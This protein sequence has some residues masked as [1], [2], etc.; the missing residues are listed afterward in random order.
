MESTPLNNPKNKHGKAEDIRSGLCGICPAGCWVK[1]V[2]KDD[3]MVSV[4]PNSE[5]PM[6]AICKIGRYSP[7]IVHD[8]QRLLYPLK[9]TGPKGTHEFTRISWDEAFTAIVNQLQTTKAKYGPEATAIYTGRGSFDMALCDH[10]QPEGVAVSSASSLLFPFG[11]PNTLGVGALCYVSFAM[12]APH[13]TMGE[14]YITMDGD[15]EQA[16]LIVIWGAN[17]ATD[18]PPWTHEQILKAKKRGAEVIAIDP[19]RN[20]TA[21]EADAQWIPIRPGT[22]GALALGLINILISEESYDEDFAENW[23]VGFDELKQLT[24]HYRAEVVEEITGVPSATIYSLARKIVSARGAVPVMYTGLEYSDSGVQAIRGVFTLWA[25]AGQLDTPGGLL[26]RMKE[27]QF[28]QNRTALQKNPDVKKALGRDRF[29]VYSHYRGESHA[30][31]LP[32][33]VLQGK[34][35]QIRD[36]IILGGSLITSWPEPDLWQKTLNGLDFLVSINRYH[37]ADSAYADI[38]LPATTMYEATSYMR[39]GAIFKIREKMMEPLGESRPDYLIQAEL[40]MRLGYG[41]LYPQS[42]EEA[43]EFAL[44]DTGFCVAEVRA[45][46][47]MVQLPPVMMQ[48]KKWEKGQLRPDGKPGFDTPSGKFEIAASLL[49]EH[50]YNPLPIYTE[51]A[52]GPLARPDLAK[53]FP[54]VFNSGTRNHY[55]FRSQHHGVPGLKEKRPEP[56]VTINSV[57]ARSR[58][59]SNTDWVWVTTPRGRLKYRAYVTD[60]IVKG[61]IDA[62]MG[63]G[64]PLGGD[65]WIK[66]NVNALTDA[67]RYDPISG[68]PIYKALLC[69]VEKAASGDKADRA[70]NELLEEESEQQNI[71]V[72]QEQTRLVYMDH[73]ATTPLNSQAFKTMEPFFKESWG[74]PS[75]IHTL[76]GDAL[77]HIDAARRQ[78]AQVINCTARR[79][80]FTASGSEADNMALQGVVLA[81][82]KKNC[83]IITSSIEHPAILATCKFL[84]SQGHSVTYL[85]VAKDGRVDPQ[86]LSKAIRPDTILV[87]IMLAN[88]EV[89]TIQP[90]KK[91]AQ[92]THAAGA[93]FHC[94]GVQ[95]LGKIAVDVEALGVDLLS[96]SSHK[97]H[98]PKGIGALYI[99]KGVNISPMIFGGSQENGLRAGTQNVPGIVG[100]G[101]ACEQANKELI[102]GEMK[103]VELLRDQLVKGVTTLIPEAQRNGS[104]ISSLPNTLN[105]T[106]PQIRGESLVLALDRRGICFSSGSACKSGNPDPSH[107]LKAMGLSDE[108]AHCSVRFSLGSGNSEEEVNFVVKCLKD[109]VQD[110]MGTIRFVGCR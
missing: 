20:G 90:I 73:N 47:G 56:L 37:T 87:S 17:P 61:A 79:L 3:R 40:A 38:V 5:H 22:D 16:E 27:N 49:D 31:A 15:I 83:H 65:E 108:E 101:T 59:I 43:L 106:L 23:T 13:V 102:N 104:A 80:V 105:M 110:T 54:L 28:P 34:P 39:Y 92:I 24:Q 86:S 29:P 32:E 60:N 42:E 81:A 46:G 103:R 50:G 94:D 89:G 82:Q 14:M 69:Q 85:K 67:N 77:A 72:N 99:R 30:I 63:G 96:L 26:F 66:C 58:G 1:A 45:K 107:V 18:S 76:G 44:E 9:R 6:G 12:I 64:G 48:Y 11:S 109:I 19:R 98:G 21:R 25:L 78:I 8:P 88:N 7:Q 91:L 70:K 4:E 93:I 41:H 75:S 10:F 55:D 74:N 84:E 33:S 97:V 95:A 71:D 35:Y 2:F 36:L 100:F 53:Q 68:F 62:D 52:E 57:D 51:P